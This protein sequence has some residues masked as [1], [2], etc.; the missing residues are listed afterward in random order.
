MP[1][2]RSARRCP[3][4]PVHNGPAQSVLRHGLDNHGI[5]S[6][7]IKTTERGKKIR[8]G[9]RQIPILGKDFR[10]CVTGTVRARF[11]EHQATARTLIR[12]R[13]GLARGEQS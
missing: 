7:H 11:E 9:F 1:Q 3:P 10:H 5:K 2:P 13:D 6:S 12:M 4:Q 8:G